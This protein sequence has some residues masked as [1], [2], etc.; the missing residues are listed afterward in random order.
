MSGVRQGPARVGVVPPLP[1]LAWAGAL[2]GARGAVP[3][4]A[5]R[6]VPVRCRVL[7]RRA[8]VAARR[9]AHRRSTVLLPG[10]MRDAVRGA[11]LT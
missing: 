11:V 8:P 10:A 9:T 1:S 2:D 4:G 5:V 6:R 3:G 7:A